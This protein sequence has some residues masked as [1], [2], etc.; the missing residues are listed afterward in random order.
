MRSSRLRAKSARLL[1]YERQNAEENRKQRE[2]EDEDEAEMEEEEE[3]RRTPKS[4]KSASGNRKRRSVA[5]SAR[6]SN[7]K[8]S[9][10]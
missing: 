2:E 7:V 6:K 9:A 10:R 3:I 4:R 8:A 5:Q 1:E